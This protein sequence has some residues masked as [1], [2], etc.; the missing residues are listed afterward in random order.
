[1]VDG[2]PVSSV[3]KL[4]V[5]PRLAPRNGRLGISFP[6]PGLKEKLT[7]LT[8]ALSR[9]MHQRRLLREEAF[10]RPSKTGKK[11]LPFGRN[12]RVMRTRCPV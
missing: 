2:L 1:M 12:Q 7:V 3:A 5:G 9:C 8:N 11:I 6:K 10:A 4:A